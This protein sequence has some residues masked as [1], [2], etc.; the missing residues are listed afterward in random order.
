MTDWF[1][2]SWPAA[3]GS[4][5]G[6]AQSTRGGFSADEG[7]GAF[8]LGDHVGDDVGIVGARRAALGAQLGVRDTQWLTQV[9]GI[10]VV[11]ATGSSAMSSRQR[12]P[13]ADAAITTEA[14][15]ALAIMTADCVPVV[16]TDAEG[17]W[18]AALHGG[19]RGLTAGIVANL[20]RQLRAGGAGSPERWL[21]WIGPA[22]CGAHYEVDLQVAAAA[23][24]CAPEAA[25][26]EIGLRA[27]VQPGRFQLE[28]ARLA[29]WQLRAQGVGSV[30][31]SGL[32]S[33]GD[34]R[35]Y[36]HRRAR[37]AGACATG[38]MATLIWRR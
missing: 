34:E 13:A 22:I 2:P 18:V 26:T 35:F 11:T 25:D 31:L 38:R 3:A 29:Q 28:L 23:R 1:A 5:I 15:L 33:H 24:S 16:L 7:F 19:W 27:G 37:A 20:V 32:C 4:A 21:A 36:S 10:D 14:N 9:H 8:N 6:L 30:T 12:A 17:S